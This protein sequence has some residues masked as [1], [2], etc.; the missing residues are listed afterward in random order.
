MS[1]LSFK[2]EARMERTTRGDD[3]M[4]GTGLT[5]HLGGIALAA[6]LAVALAAPPA[7]AATL[8]VH[9]TTG[10]F[11]TIQAALDAAAPGDTVKVKAKGG[12]G[13]NGEYHEPW[14][15]IT[16]KIEFVCDKKAVIDGAIP[17]GVPAFLN[18][19]AGPV[20]LPGHGLLVINHPGF[21]S[22]TF[23]GAAA[24]AVTARLAD[25]TVVRNCTFRFW[26]THVDEPDISGTFP[27]PGLYTDR[28][29]D[30]LRIGRRESDVRYRPTL[31][32]GRRLIRQF[33]AAEYRM[34]PKQPKAAPGCDGRLGRSAKALRKVHLCGRVVDQS[35]SRITTAERSGY[36]GL[37]LVHRL[38]GVP[39]RRP[40]IRHQ[41]AGLAAIGTFH[42]ERKRGF[43]VD[44][45]LGLMNVHVG[46]HG[47]AATIAMRRARDF[48]LRSA[49]I[50]RVR[51]DLA[52]TR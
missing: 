41:R 6:L 27:K 15:M 13:V 1:R 35:H 33:V 22:G 14:L 38:I 21:A 24:A 43:P 52:D 2:K 36:F 12:T 29:G 7:L 19:P 25:G 45:G 11:S 26:D 18:S 30:C 47:R 37:K 20:S 9:K 17:T 32:D 51:G 16:K 44:P 48:H 42:G 40:D 4:E 31:A 50:T 28:E 10:N 23:G 39:A 46:S 3:A 34:H 8:T 5:K 49:P